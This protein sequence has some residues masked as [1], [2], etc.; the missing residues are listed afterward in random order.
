MPFV[1]VV[2][3]KAYFKRFQV[4]F[5]RRRE[6]RTDY[7]QRHKL[8]TQDKN[9]YQSPKYRLCVRFTNKYVHVQ[10]IYAEI[11]GDKCMCHASSAELPKYGLSVG[12]K[13]YAASYCTGLLV[14]RR[15]LKQIG[16]D[17]V[18]TGVEEPT[19]DVVSTKD[20]TNGRTYFVEE[21]DD[22][23]K[24]FR[25]LLDVGIKNTTTGSRVF[26]AM[27]GAS[28]GGLDI[29]HSNKRFPGYVRDT[30]SF[31]ASVHKEHIMGGHVADYMRE[32]EEDDEENYQKHFAKYIELDL[33]ADDL[34]EL[35]EKVHAAIREDPTRTEVEEFTNID[36]SFAR[37]IKKTYDQRKI[38]SN[39]KKAT[40]AEPEDDD[41]E[42]EDEEDDE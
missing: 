22:D 37:D 17:E 33:E 14:A 42:E 32:M 3:N 23:K 11:D 4:K 15:L 39:A 18:Y 31:D 27:K 19:G 2:K 26:G 36:K 38:D 6:G 12:L 8:I 20:P 7:R 1:K 10:I 16:L 21:L 28:D 41:E 24:P 13:N 25:A 34:E 29:P 5:R 9:K 30:K 35:Y 40:F